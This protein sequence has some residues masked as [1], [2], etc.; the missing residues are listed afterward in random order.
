MDIDRNPKIGG[1]ADI[2]VYW[3]DAGNSLGL[4]VTHLVVWVKLAAVHVVVM[5]PEHCDQLSRMEDIHSDRAAT[6]HKHK[7]WAAAP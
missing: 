2:Q 5:T 1:T 3:S 7:L 6:W 4:W